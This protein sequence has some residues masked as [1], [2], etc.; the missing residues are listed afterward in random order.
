MAGMSP[1]RARVTSSM[2]GSSLSNGSASV[3]AGARVLGRDGFGKD[4][5]ILQ[6]LKEGKSAFSQVTTP[7]RPNLNKVAPAAGFVGGMMALHP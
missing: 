4:H 7:N 5:V 3:S 1:P 6:D 2:V